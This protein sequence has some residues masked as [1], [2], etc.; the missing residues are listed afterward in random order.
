MGSRT[1]KGSGREGRALVWSCRGAVAQLLCL[2][3]LGSLLCAG[4]AWGGTLVDGRAWEMVSPP[5]KGG[6]PVEALTREGGLILASEE[7]DGLAYVVD[8]ALGEDVE[9][10]RSPEMEQVLAVR[11][12]DGWVS[13]DIATPSSV[14]KGI[15]PGNAPE[16][17]FF[18]PDLSTSL[19]EPSEPGAEPPLAAGVTQATM[20]VRN[21]STATYL[22][23]VTEQDTAPGTEFGGRIHFV[24]A[25]PDL[26][27]VVIAS[28]VALTGASSAK[29]LYEWS[30]GQLQLVSV[31]SDGVTPAQS[32]ELGFYG[33]VVAHAVS[34]DGSRI[35]WTNKEDPNTRG[36]HLYLRDTSRG[37]TLQL[38]TAQGVSEPKKGSAVFQAASSDGSRILFTDRERLTANS[39]AE[40][41]QG[42]GKPDLYECQVTEVGGKLACGLEDLTVDA[43]EGEHANVQGLLLGAS[44]DGSSVFLVAQGVLANNENAN[45]EHALAEQ[46]NLYELHHEGAEWVRTFIATLSAQDSPEWEGNQNGNPAY[47]T[48]RVSPNGRYLAFM[49]AAPITGYDN[50]D[51]SPL[52]EG[53]RDEEVYLYD[54]LTAGLRC[55]SCDPDGA[56]PEGALDTEKSGEGLGLLVDRRLIWG[57]E[58]H[59][60]W[61]AGNIPGWTSQ[62]L[63]SASFQSRY[64]SDEGRL[65]F[66]SPV[67]L[68]P[69]ATNG[70]EDVYEFEPTGVG[71]CQSLSG[72]CI[73]LLSGGSSDHESA[74]ME[75]TPDGSNVFFLTDAQLL[76]QDTD[77][78]FDIYD[79][80]ECTGLSPCLTPPVPAAAA[81]EEIPTCRPAQESPQIPGGPSGTAIFTGSGNVVSGPP[82]AKHEVEATKAKKPL[83][84]AQL[85]AGALRLCR[86]RHRHARKQRE[87]CER[88]AR[89]RYA[90]QHNAKRHRAKRSA[91]NG[92]K[93]GSGR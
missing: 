67:N 44:E 7:G 54:S 48:A 24:G 79:A 26:S 93:R 73:S 66:N 8:G 57:R 31:L 36:G 28:G 84:R 10:N 23:V 18:S 11:T 50:V 32:A 61:L 42:V 19:V 55:V 6:A 2:V 4:E 12:A 85:L 69:A 88:S 91:A 45:H 40:P 72:G 1:V 47:V 71:S 15:A 65:Y 83:T 52:A 64:L 25:S 21:D 29:G 70:K 13:Q 14:A 76:P 49:S 37:E 75:A 51:T 27:H 41:G 77:T 60:H 78:A 80:R 33:A 9:G 74:F 62:S 53:A 56:P 86:E 38:D 87:T 22:P 89:K 90:S 82:R 81:C 39:T 17:Q 46:D 63:T 58:G 68:V 3:L 30:G 92:H 16:Y 59:E 34:N 35:I 5:A 43:N 20:Y